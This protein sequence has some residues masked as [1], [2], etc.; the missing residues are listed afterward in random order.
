MKIEFLGV[1]GGLLISQQM[2]AQT[3]SIANTQELSDVVVTATNGIKSK[4]RAD[5]TEIIG[6]GQ[7][8]RAACCNLGESFTT[9][10]S[11]DVSY[12]DAATGARQIK[13]L[14]LSG[15]YVQMLTE[16][17][18]NLRGAALPYSLGYVPGPW[19]QSIQVSK[20]ASSVKNGYE[21]TTGQINIEFLKPQG[22]DGVHANVYLDSELKTEVNLDGS[23]HLNDRLSTAT[24][25]HF[26]NR[27]MDHDGNSDG[28]MDMPKLR[29]YNLMHRWAYVSP[30][31]ISQLMLR[32]LRDERDGG[33][34]RKHANPVSSEP[35]YSTSVKTNRYEMQWKNGFTINADHNTSVALMLHGSW[36]DADHIFGMTQY[37]VTQKN[38]YA[39]LM[40]ETDFNDNH[41]LSVGASFNHNY[42]DERFNPLGASPN[43]E[44]KVTKETTPGIYAQYTYKLGEKLTVMPGVRWDHSSHYGS[45]VTPR[46]HIKYSPSS[47]ITFR[48]SVGKGYRSPHALA[49][50]VTLLASG[51]DIIIDS[52]IKQEEAWNAGASIGMNIPISGKN[53]ELNA[54]YYYTDF[55]HQMIMN[56]DGSKGE[57]TLS[58]ENLDGKSYSHT[59]QVDA[60]YPLLSGMSATAAFRLNDVKCTY[61][62][63]LRKKPLT[64]RYKGLLTLSYKTPLELWQFDVTGQLNG[65]GELYDQSR[66]PAYFQLQAQI[67]RDFRN[68]SLYLGGENLTNY[69]IDNPI[70]NSHHPWNAAFDATQVWGPITGAM[71]YIGVRFKLEKL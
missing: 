60:T 43:A 20:G 3:D 58:I 2:I 55:K 21:S 57:H 30:V 27:Q 70:I 51:R 54:E 35:L 50:N 49:E 12:S 8:I 44:S 25:L 5:N 66:Y 33:Q 67:T 26:E 63:V 68:F 34:S 65:G 59:L 32:G 48:T 13:L 7:L 18:P 38:G 45:F 62:G 36:H 52:D 29:Q 11:V 69:K 71:A 6:K 19:M 56:F 9:N 24:L 4:F 1:C 10:P 31:W 41:N 37:D 42:Y 40:F 14:G 22:V 16:N 17:I 28:F 23:I 64:S 61:D 46:L 47:V 15:T 53:L 39:Q